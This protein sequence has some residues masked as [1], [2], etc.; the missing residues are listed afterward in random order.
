MYQTTEAVNQ[1]KTDRAGKQ[2]LTDFLQV[3][4]FFRAAPAEKSN[5]LS[6]CR[7]AVGSSA[8]LR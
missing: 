8:G 6:P 3:G 5:S 2:A 4:L 7:V 1:G